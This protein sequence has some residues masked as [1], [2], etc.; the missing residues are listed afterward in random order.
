[1]ALREGNEA[2]AAQQDIA[3]RNPGRPRR[4]IVDIR[5]F[6]GKEDKDI[7]EWLIRWDIAA[8]AN[9]WTP[10]QQLTMIPAYLTGRAARILWRMSRE[11]RNDLD[12]LKDQ[13]D[14]TFNTEE[15]R[16]LARQKLQEITQGPKES[17]AEL[18]KRVDKLVVKGHDGLDG[19]E[20]RD[21]I[22]CESFV[23]GLRA[24]IKETMWEKCPASFQEA[25]QA[26]ERREV[27][28]SS[29]GR[30]FRINEVSDNLVGLV[31]KF[32]EERVRSNDEIWK[33]IQ[34]L[35]KAVQGIA[36]Q[37][38]QPIHAPPVLAAR[39]SLET[40]RPVPT[41]FYCRQPGHLKRNCPKKPQNA[42]V[43]RSNQATSTPSS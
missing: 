1:M 42:T 41:C 40:G 36:A 38:A 8:T 12:E 23:K 9:D 15:K 11:T 2:V 22:A 37:Q 28:L 32:N 3:E 25:I 19:A 34:D 30:R 27:F 21:R 31:Q 26:A 6:S 39:A 4:T 33:A 35:T 24:D 10:D 14:E 43:S 18:S 7:S 16:Y 20:R 5:P 13:L 29:L 17:V